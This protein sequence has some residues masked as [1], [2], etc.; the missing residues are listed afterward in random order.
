MS[1]QVDILHN[2]LASLAVL[3]SRTVAR[4][5]SLGHT[6]ASHPG[7]ADK[8]ANVCRL[9]ERQSRGLENRAAEVA[10]GAMV[11]PVSAEAARAAPAGEEGLLRV[12]E[13][14]CE[15]Y[16]ALHRLAA[17]YFVLQTL[18]HRFRDSEAAADAGTTSHLAMRHTAQCVRAAADICRLLKDVPGLG[19]GHLRMGMPML[20]SGLQPRSVR[21]CQ[22]SPTQTHQCLD[23]RRSSG[24]GRRDPAL[25]SET[26]KFR[27]T[28]RCS[29]WRRA[30]QHR[31]ARSSR[32]RHSSEDAS[33]CAP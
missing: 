12:T 18:S 31:G 28:G 24:P 17:E 3:S 19:S 2:Q 8:L 30:P 13:S 22:D 15:A 33:G 6:A 9:L 14:I 10:R 29:R 21:M 7:A 11:D 25:Y 5:E 1:Q 26:R 27:G 23:R 16:V 4:L 20:M 32:R